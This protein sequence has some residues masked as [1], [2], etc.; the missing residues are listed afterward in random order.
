MLGIA[1][2]GRIGYFLLLLLV[3][4][5]VLTSYLF[6]RGQIFFALILIP[7]ILVLA[8]LNVRFF[9]PTYYAHFLDYWIRY[10]GI[11]TF[12]KRIYVGDSQDI[13]VHLVPSIHLW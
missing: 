1:L 9:F 8:L 4:G 13:S 7:F 11:L 2:G 5:I 6:V 10:D 3:S 12:P